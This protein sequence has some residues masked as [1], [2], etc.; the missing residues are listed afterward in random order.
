[1]YPIILKH[2]LGSIYNSS[3]KRKIKKQKKITENFKKKFNINKINKLFIN[4][5]I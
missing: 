1:M 4:L 5:K 2:N 3:K